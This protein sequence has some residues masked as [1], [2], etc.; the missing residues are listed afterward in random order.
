MLLGLVVALVGDLAQESVQVDVEQ[1][2]EDPLV[3]HDVLSFV[4]SSVLVEGEE[5]DHESLCDQ[6]RV[7][8]VFRLR[9]LHV[10]DQA[11]LELVGDALD[12]AMDELLVLAGIL[13]GCLVTAHLPLTPLATSIL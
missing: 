8:D 4:E 9:Q 2:R 5:E 3:A 12:Q 7:P 13:I 11:L 1:D 10:A 6:S